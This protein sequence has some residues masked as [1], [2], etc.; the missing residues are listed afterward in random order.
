MKRSIV[1]CGHCDGTGKCSR[2]EQGFSCSSCQ[3]EAGIEDR[4]D[5]NKVHCSICKGTG[6]ILKEC[7]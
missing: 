3:R 4:G 6:K 2:G 7:Y 5:T 1:K